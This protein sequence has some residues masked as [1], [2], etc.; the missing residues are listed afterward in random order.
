MWMPCGPGGKRLKRLAKMRTWHM[1]N[2]KYGRR[3]TVPKSLFEGVG[4]RWHMRGDWER[5]PE[6]VVGAG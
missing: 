1:P 6:R 3:I 4:V 2:L 5:Q